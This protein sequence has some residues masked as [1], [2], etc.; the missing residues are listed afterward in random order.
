[1]TAPTICRMVSPVRAL[2]IPGQRGSLAQ[3]V[4][5]ARVGRLGGFEH[6]GHLLERAGEAFH[7]WLGS[8]GLGH[9]GGRVP[10]DVFDCVPV[11][12]RGVEQFH[13]GVPGAVQHDV[14]R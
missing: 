8:V 14:G 10:D 13:G 12:S 3:R 9:L 11:D 5:G 7:V 2:S 6:A 4:S 1:M